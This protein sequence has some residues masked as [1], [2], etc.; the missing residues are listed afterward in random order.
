MSI[1]PDT[2]SGALV[3]SVFDFVA[4][5]FV[6]WGISFFI[7]GLGFINSKFPESPEGNKKS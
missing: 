1:I 3:L 5:F 2:F 4:C 7:K 6:L